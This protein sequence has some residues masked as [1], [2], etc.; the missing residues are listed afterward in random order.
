[1]VVR[2]VAGFP[3]PERVLNN[4][5][6]GETEIIAQCF[7][8]RRQCTEI[9][10]DERQVTEALRHCGEQ[11][12]AWRLTPFTLARGLRTRRNFIRIV[13][14]D[15]VIDTHKIEALRRTSDA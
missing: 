15:E 10:C 6:T 1:M 3:A 4:A 13:E 9:L 5:H 12:A 14:A 11:F 8:F 2:H 7:D